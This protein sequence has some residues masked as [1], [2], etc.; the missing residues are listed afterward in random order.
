MREAKDKIVRKNRVVR[1][2]MV[3]IDDN[4]YRGL[5]RY[6]DNYKRSKRWIVEDA[7]NCWI[8]QRDK[9]TKERQLLAQG[10]DK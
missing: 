10:E 4:V 1:R 9:E 3:E 2:L 8:I 6:C 7:I 5:E